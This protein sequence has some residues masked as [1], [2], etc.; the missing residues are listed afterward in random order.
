MFS[1]AL[2]FNWGRNLVPKLT[3]APATDADAVN[4]GWG[5][6][7]EHISSRLNVF[8]FLY[9]YITNTSSKICKGIWF[10]LDSAHWRLFL[11]HHAIS[12]WTTLLGASRCC[13]GSSS[14]SVFLLHI[15]PV[16]DFAGCPKN[17]CGL[18]LQP[19]NQDS[20]YTILA[21]SYLLI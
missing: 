2:C 20:V 17:S 15:P 6:W 18:T 3:L 14:P 12:E 13:L 11:I 5:R 16:L 7:A 10:G 9:T 1:L 8:Y 19:I 21:L 4:Q